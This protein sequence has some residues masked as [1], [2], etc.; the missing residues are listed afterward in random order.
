[1]GTRIDHLVIGASNLVQGAAYVKEQLG[2]DIPYGGAH[3]TMGTHNH[4]MRLGDELFLEVIALNPDREPPNR[5]RWYGL[6]DPHV[7]QSLYN[8]PALLSWVVNT[9]NI[10]KL[11]QKTRGA[12]GEATLISRGKLS[13][14]FGLPDDGRL[15]AGGMLPYIIDWQ[16]DSHPAKQ[17][18]DAGCRFQGLDIYHPYPAWLDS[19]LESIG[20]ADLARIHPLPKNSQA[21]LEAHIET[22]SGPRVLRSHAGLWSTE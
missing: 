7:R 19:I 21:F 13:W 4:L 3:D 17:M 1:M 10:N 8:R 6:D 5:P 9:E 16:V 20:A 18:A 12:F 2:V 11:L 14:Y 22:P 15:L